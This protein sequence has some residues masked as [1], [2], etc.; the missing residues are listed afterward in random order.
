MISLAIVY[1]LPV[2]FGNHGYGRAPPF[3][4]APARPGSVFWANVIAGRARPWS[5]LRASYQ[6]VVTS[7]FRLV[8]ETMFPAPSYTQLSVNPSGA[9]SLS[10]RPAASY[11]AYVMPD[12]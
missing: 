12:G 2:S 1:V 6:D 8:D 4:G 5:R 10:L 7:P 3:S 9:V 11:V